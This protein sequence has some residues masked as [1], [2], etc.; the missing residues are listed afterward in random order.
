MAEVPWATACCGRSTVAIESIAKSRTRVEPILNAIASACRCHCHCY[1]RWLGSPL[2]S[3]IMRPCLPW[4]LDFRCLCLLS[5]TGKAQ[6]FGTRQ[7]REKMNTPPTLQLS[8]FKATVRRTN[9]RNAAPTW[10]PDTCRHPQ[11][12]VERV[13]VVNRSLLEKNSVRL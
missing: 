9:Q 13:S 12:A 6:S 4:S 1:C 11:P 2:Q 7:A 8:L 5:R 3:K 10:I